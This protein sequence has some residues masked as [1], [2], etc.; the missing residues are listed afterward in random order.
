[1]KLRVLSAF[2]AVA[3]L[4]G[5]SA[6]V[7]AQTAE[8]QVLPEETITGVPSHTLPTPPVHP[9]KYTL[10]MDVRVVKDAS[11]TTNTVITDARGTELA[12]WAEL[13][14]QCL[15]EKPVLVRVVGESQVPFI[16]NKAEGKLKLNAN[17]KPVCS[18]L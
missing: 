8:T 10:P 9:I 7:F 6:P 11:I 5:V 14:R 13:V 3:L 2:S 12:A 17:D 1:M 16:V 15:R 4:A 18:I